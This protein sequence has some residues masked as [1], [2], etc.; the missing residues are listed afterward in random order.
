MPVYM[1]VH[2]WHGRRTFTK[3]SPGGDTPRSFIQFILEPLYKMFAQ[4]VG[5]VDSTLPQ[6][7]DEL[8]KS[9]GGCTLQ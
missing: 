2:C 4:V 7:L 8:G 1:C 6:T 3:K 5:D 9:S